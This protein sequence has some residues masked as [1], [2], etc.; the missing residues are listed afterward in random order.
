MPLLIYSPIINPRK[1][2]I[3]NHI[4]V[5]ILGIEY[6]FTSNKEAFIQYTE[7]KLNYAPFP[8]GDELHLAQHPFIDE[9]TIQIQHPTFVNYENYNVPFAL[10]NPLFPF[11]IF[12]ASFY[13]LSRYEEYL[14]N[15]KDS[16]N[17]Y[18]AINSMAFTHGFLH[19]PVIDNWAFSL[20]AKLKQRYP[21]L[22]STARKFTFIP[23]ID[24]DNPYYLK[25]ETFLRK[26]VKIT[27][28][29]LKGNFSLFKHDPYDT[30]AYLKSLH[31]H[32]N[33]QPIFFFLVGNFHQYDTAPAMQH[34]NASYKLLIQSIEDY[35]QVGI[36][37]SYHSNE[38]GTALASEIQILASA[39]SDKKIE[40]ARQHYLKL[41][42]PDTY[43]NLLNKG[44]K[45]D[46]TMG[47]ASHTGF[48]ASTCTP[49][50]WYDLQNETISDLTLHPF[51]VMDQ[52]LKKYL[53]LN[54]HEATINTQNLIDEV[55]KVNGTF[56]SL[57]HNET[58]SDFGTWKSW[59][60]VYEEMLEYAHQNQNT[61]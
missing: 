28:A 13:L 8:F 40:I 7:A 19:K 39:L 9:K 36:H 24:V 16:H 26:Y 61:N 17:R 52:T 58:L 38:N 21:N 4:L 18:Q 11:D 53:N 15:T 6:T 5:D 50:F 59:R 25:T 14:P 23:T 54:L 41:N 34:Y 30:Y 57:W 46:Y 48:R 10:K 56:I 2:Y 44:I 12:S 55:K 37:P 43:K 3:L 27:K 42:L 32:Y 45:H 22:K 47:Y 51:A 1:T 35:A 20:L 49:F 29:L 60:K 33:L 31:Q